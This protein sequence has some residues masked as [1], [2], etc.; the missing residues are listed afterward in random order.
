MKILIIGCGAW[1]STVALLL[2]ENKKNN[3][4]VYDNDK[5]KILAFSKKSPNNIS[6]TN[7][8]NSI[9]T[10][11]IILAVPF[12]YLRETLNELRENYT[13]Q[14]IINLSKGI[15]QTSFKTASMLIEEILET[16]KIVNL[17]G[18]THAEEVS[19]K[20]P[21]AIISSSKNIKLAEKI[22]KLFNRNYFRVYTSNDI[23]GTELGGAVKNVFGV[24]AGISDGLGFGINTKSALLT[25]G[26]SEMV[27]LK[28]IYECKIN[29]F[30]GLS[31][32]G[33]IMTTCFSKYSRNRNFGEYIGK[34][35]LVTTAIEKVKQVVE[36]YY[37]VKTMNQISNKH[38]IDLPISNEVYKII[39]KNKNPQESVLNLMTRILKKE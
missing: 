10:E 3:I 34:G 2:S 27:K 6:I 11:V 4:F 30:S 37:T 32:I 35:I 9:K 7:N 18:P 19:Q 20:I 36:G 23:I 21:S 16:N 15:E 29:T 17:T 39:Y 13:N 8:I 38:K 28:N 26:I 24:A 12:K 22:Q 5:K 1:G 25:R 14:I 33:D 31:G